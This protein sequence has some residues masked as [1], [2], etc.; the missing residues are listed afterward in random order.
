L[1]FCRRYCTL[2]HQRKT[3]RRKRKYKRKRRKTPQGKT[4]QKRKE[5]DEESQGGIKPHQS[6]VAEGT[7]AMNVEAYGKNSTA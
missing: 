7:Q 1:D 2:L 5:K 4:S 3:N 6:P